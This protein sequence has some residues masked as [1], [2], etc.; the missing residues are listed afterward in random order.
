MHVEA[1]LRQAGG[2]NSPSLKFAAKK[3]EALMM[4]PKDKEPAEGSR[5]TVDKELARQGKGKPQA[6]GGKSAERKG[7]ERGAGKK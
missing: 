4:D 7:T 6:D 2:N 5:E 1:W 3:L